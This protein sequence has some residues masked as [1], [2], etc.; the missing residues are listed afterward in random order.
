MVCATFVAAI[1]HDSAADD[2][3]TG[4]DWEDKVSEEV[5]CQHLPF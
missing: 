3:D 2:E 4:E 1:L 5:G